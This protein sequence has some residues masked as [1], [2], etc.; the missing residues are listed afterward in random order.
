MADYPFLTPQF[1]QA[2]EDSRSAVPRTGWQPC[3]QTLLTDGRESAFMPLYVKSHS[4]GEYVFD[5]S[6]A[7]AYRRHGLSYYPKLLT[8]IPFTPA[9]GPRIRF[10]P[11]ANQE[12]LAGT[13]IDDT[14]ALAE[15][16]GASSCCNIATLPFVMGA[17][18]SCRVRK[19]SNFPGMN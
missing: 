13:L 16:S 17:M 19:R 11:S 4:M 10:Q 5:W 12:K 8:A 15:T 7:D 6:W 1:L 14:I 3:H 9:T 18:S 2:L